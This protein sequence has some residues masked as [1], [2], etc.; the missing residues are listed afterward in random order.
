MSAPRRQGRTSP[1]DSSPSLPV[2][3]KVSECTQGVAEALA[4]AHDSTPSCCPVWK[5]NVGIREVPNLWER[6][7]AST[8]EQDKLSNMWKRLL[9]FVTVNS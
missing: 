9:K 8:R 7:L 5:A 6:S 1:L 4:R 2:K 3:N